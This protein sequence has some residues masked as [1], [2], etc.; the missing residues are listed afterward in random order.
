MLVSYTYRS[1]DPDGEENNR[2][3]TVRKEVA[4][5]MKT[6]SFYTVVDLGVISPKAPTDKSRRDSEVPGPVAVYN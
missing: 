6:F 3:S 4:H 1:D 2:L 5:E